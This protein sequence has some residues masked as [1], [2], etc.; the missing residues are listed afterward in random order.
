MVRVERVGIYLVCRDVGLGIFEFM[1]RYSRG[2][3]DQVLQR[4]GQSVD[5]SGEEVVSVFYRKWFGK[6]V[7]GR[8]SR[9]ICVEGSMKSSGLVIQV[10]GEWNNEDWQG[11]FEVVL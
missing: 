8:R 9:I 4:V 1:G 2:N 7:G 6:S 11:R 3:S 10:W 5:D